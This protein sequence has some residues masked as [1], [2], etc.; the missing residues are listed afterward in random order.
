MRQSSAMLRSFTSWLVTSGKKLKT[1]RQSRVNYPLIDARYHLTGHRNSAGSG[2]IFGVSTRA[3]T[4]SLRHPDITDLPRVGRK[5][6]IPE[7]TRTTRRQPHYNRTCIA[8]RLHSPRLHL[9]PSY[10]LTTGRLASGRHCCR[11]IAE[12][13]TPQQRLTQSY[14]IELARMTHLS[15][16]VPDTQGESE[17]QCFIE[18]G[19]PSLQTTIQS[20]VDPTRPLTRDRIGVQAGPISPLPSL[21][22]ACTFFSCQSLVR[23]AQRDRHGLA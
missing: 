7:R 6:M 16:A 5:A 19:L 14:N 21:R 17:G 4:P 2:S 9:L 20:L 13:D 10:Q 11:L 12:I 15:E 23:T 22:P 18:P 8:L 1:L 3:G